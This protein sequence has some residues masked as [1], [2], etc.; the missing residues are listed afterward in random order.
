MRNDELETVYRQY[1]R[2]VLLYAYSLCHDM[3]RAEELASDTFFKAFLA[4]E[5]N[6][7]HIKYWLL[8]VC[9]N[10]YIDQCR[11]QAKA[12]A[13]LLEEARVQVAAWTQTAGEVLPVILQNERNRALYTGLLQL[14][15]AQ[16]E[17]LL[18]FYFAGCGI[19]EI[20]SITGGSPGAV[21]TALSRARAKLKAILEEDANALF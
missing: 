13:V 4:L 15:S 10:L 2:E 7:G 18:L 20:A 16:R 8:R 14:P 21:K 9:R 6:V 17:L 1:G 11:R 3:T 19:R 5:K 12:G